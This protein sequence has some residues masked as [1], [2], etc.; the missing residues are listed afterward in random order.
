MAITGNGH[1]LLILKA[2]IYH[3]S[4]WPSFDLQPSFRLC[5][6]TSRNGPKLLVT[7]CCYINLRSKN[8]MEFLGLFVK[9]WNGNRSSSPLNPHSVF[10]YTPNLP[11]RC[12]ICKEMD[13][14]PSICTSITSRRRIK[15]SWRGCGLREE[16]G[17]CRVHA[18][19]QRLLKADSV[20]ALYVFS[21][22]L[23]LL[24]PLFVP[25]F[26]CSFPPSLS[27]TNICLALPHVYRVITSLIVSLYCHLPITRYSCPQLEKS[28]A[29]SQTSCFSFSSPGSECLGPV[30]SEALLPNQPRAS[31]GLRLLIAV[32]HGVLAKQ[33]GRQ[34]LKTTVRWATFVKKN[35]P[36]SLCS[37]RA[38]ITQVPAAINDLARDWAT[39][40]KEARCQRR[41][42]ERDGGMD[43]SRRRNERMVIWCGNMQLYAFSVHL[44]RYKH[45]V[46]SR[47]RHQ[48]LPLGDTAVVT[49]C[50]DSHTDPHSDTR[51]RFASYSPAYNSDF[52]SNLIRAVL[53]LWFSDPP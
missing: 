17:T 34:S 42:L 30:S 25:P 8:V 7:K 22:H 19:Q 11:H 35:L 33:S 13:V 24:L 18:Y 16:T 12:L 39:I 38:G 46:P 28:L 3:D 14:P 37:S 53:T 21:F 23:S 5:E 20:S 26:R 29:L 44:E 2:M 48:Y 36:S 1:I 52:S 50:L 4:L 6:S 47:V 10:V 31:S 45:F 9:C 27:S 15:W 41:S 51:L 43:G 49:P 40:K 32:G